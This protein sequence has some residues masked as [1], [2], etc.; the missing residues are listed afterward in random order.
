MAAVSTLDVYS[1]HQMEQTINSYIIHGYSM[2]NRTPASATMVKR[3]EFSILWLVIGLILCVL[4]LLIYLII[5]ATEKDRI[6]EIRLAQLPLHADGRAL[7]PATQLSEDGQWWWDGSRW[8]PVDRSA[9]L[10]EPS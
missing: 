9:E 1:E 6:V 2:M 8:Q 10:A 7:P 5:Y 3:K 4:P